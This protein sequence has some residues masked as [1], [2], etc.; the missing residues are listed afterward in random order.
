[1]QS[2]DTGRAKALG[3]SLI[4]F[5]DLHFLDIDV[6]T[7]ARGLARPRTIVPELRAAA[8]T[9]TLRHDEAPLPKFFAAILY[10]Q[11]LLHSL[12]TAQ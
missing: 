2:A 5:H 8:T 1:L 3:D 7:T 11:S 12:L 9:L 6:P 10:S 4:P